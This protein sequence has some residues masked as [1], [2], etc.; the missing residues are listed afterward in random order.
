MSVPR[1]CADNGTCHH[2]CPRVHGHGSPCWRVLNAGPLSNF[3][4]RN[5]WPAYVVA[6]HEHAEEVRKALGLD[7][8]SPEPEWP[9]D[10]SE[11]FE[12]WRF[13]EDGKP[14]C[15]LHENVTYPWARGYVSKAP[16]GNVK[17]VRC[18]ITREVTP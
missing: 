3:F 9:D 8:E 10:R 13:S 4:P 17:I 2:D 11:T 5:E 16:H 18:T 14:L 1:A 12:V 7:D 15:L 6:N